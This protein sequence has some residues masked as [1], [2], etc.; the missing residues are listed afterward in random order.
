MT[1]E[2]IQTLAQQIVKAPNAC[3]FAVA[4]EG[5]SKG[6]EAN[7]GIRNGSSYNTW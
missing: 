2:A 7:S 3:N 5:V 6:V 4:R 1:D